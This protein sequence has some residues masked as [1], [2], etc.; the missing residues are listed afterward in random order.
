MT[1]QK[2]HRIPLVKEII[3]KTLADDLQP[4]IPMSNDEINRRYEHKSV[5]G[6]THVYSRKNGAL[7]CVMTGKETVHQLYDVIHSFVYGWGI[8]NED[9]RIVY[10]RDDQDEFER[11][12]K[13]KSAFVCPNCHIPMVKGENDH[14]YCVKCDWKKIK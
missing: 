12:M 14:Y 4:V 10:L 1:K 2:K 6:D 3:I 9:G 5:N 7:L 11:L 13:L 8:T